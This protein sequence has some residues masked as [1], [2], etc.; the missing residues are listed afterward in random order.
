LSRERRVK[1]NCCL[2]P[3]DTRRRGMFCQWRERESAK[4]FMTGAGTE[5]MGRTGVSPRHKLRDH[6]PGSARKA[7]VNH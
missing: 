4:R 3:L 6:P 1:E 2:H 5:T 7:R